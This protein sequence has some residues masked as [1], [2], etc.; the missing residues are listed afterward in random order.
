MDSS[1]AARAV[2]LLVL[3]LLSAF[4]SG[5]E[6][7]LTAINKLRMRSLADDNVKGAKN[8]LKLIDDPTKMLSAL[9]IGNNVI[10]LSASAL[11]TTMA[12]DIWGNNWV[13]LATGVLTLLILVFG[14]ITP[15][16]ISAIKAEKIALRIAGPILL[17]TK[18]L[19]PLIF[20][21]NKL[22]N[23]VMKLFGIDPNE[24]PTS[25]TESE[26][27][28][29][30][31]VSHE[32]G[33]LESE[34]RRMITNVVDFGDSLA[35]DVMVPR[36]DMSFASVDLSY[37]E[38]VQL[39]SID[40]YTRLPVYSENR[41]NVIGIVNLKDI[42]FYSGKKED[43]N[44]LDII[45]EP[46]FTYEFKKTSELLIEMR[47]DSIALAIVLDE[48]G[49]TAGL[50]TIEDLLEEIVGEIRDE[51]DE[52]EED[53]IQEL[54]ENEYIVDGNTKLDDI[55]EVLGLDIESSDYD[56][57]AG[58][59]IYLLDHLPE[60]GESVIE[61]N[62]TYTVASVDKNRIDKVHIHIA[63]DDD[64]DELEE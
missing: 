8:A 22:C 61:N 34:E 38:L 62:V 39:F 54:S 28:T 21:I 15:K 56:S 13:G 45:R 60:E 31:E 43:F 9:L 4:F 10:N 29:I 59:I 18:L 19:T 26:L 46:Y 42:F 49:A 2:I 41:D 51:Y 58:H 63:N 5:S 35:K 30:L 6:T 7:A 47:M 55:D 20:I 36:I 11:A 3:L 53:C 40:K 52:D 57:I 64:G 1:D 12:I 48:Y 44:I 23:G 50:I 14:E 17:I 24:K 27:R 16:S 25:M 32:E 37:D 33:V